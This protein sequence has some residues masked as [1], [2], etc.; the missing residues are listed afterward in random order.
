[1]IKQ[2]HET[3]VHVQLLVTVQRVSPELSAIDS[4]RKQVLRPIRFAAP[5]A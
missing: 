5:L 2:R 4:L 3:V 1:V